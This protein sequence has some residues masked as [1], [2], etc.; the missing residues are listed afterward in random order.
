MMSFIFLVRGQRDVGR[1][2]TH[3]TSRGRADT[4]LT[5]GEV[6]CR[7]DLF[8]KLRVYLST[9]STSKD[10]GRIGWCALFTLY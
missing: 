5:S 7:Y 3:V 10:K 8:K 9:Y 4:P 1:H 2:V 6:C